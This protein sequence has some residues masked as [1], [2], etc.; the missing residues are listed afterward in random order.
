M[1]G[2]LRVRLLKGAS[3]LQPGEMLACLLD[4]EHPET[5][6]Q[7][8]HQILSTGLLTWARPD[9]E[10]RALPLGLNRRQA[11]RVRLCAELLTKLETE[12]WAMPTPITAPADVLAHVSD[13]RQACQEK[14]VAIYLDSR[15]RPLRRELISVGGLRASVIQPK[16]VLAPALALPA[17]AL[18][19]VH[20]HPSGDTTPSSEDLEVTR[21]LA[22]AARLLGL[23][24][25]D[26]LIVARGRYT[27]I[28]E[29]GAI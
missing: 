4:Q 9:C 16:D 19:L 17:A 6:L 26:H 1:V 12:S 23:E 20:N 25:L 24:L 29:T 10:E 11:L 15:H 13:L 27:S 22:Q 14:V 18:I 28:K 7:A 2:G 8:A 3:E 5:M 21:Q